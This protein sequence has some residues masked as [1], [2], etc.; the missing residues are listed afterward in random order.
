ML[1]VGLRQQGFL[2]DSQE[3]P[4]TEAP[5][6]RFE[7]TWS[8]I[9]LL[10]C[11]QHGGPSRKRTVLG[12]CRPGSGFACDQKTISGWAEHFY[13]D[14]IKLNNWQVA[15]ASL[16]P[17]CAESVFSRSHSTAPGA[18]FVHQSARGNWH[19]RLKLPRRRGQC[20][21]WW[22]DRCVTVQLSACTPKGKDLL[23]PRMLKQEKSE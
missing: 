11:S 21:S 9:C 7:K 1:F 3:D 18:I 2:W 20:R 19:V 13:S 12:P 4:C 22:L 5:C 23:S 16:S 6:T 15:N 10:F 14:P 8:S 17:S